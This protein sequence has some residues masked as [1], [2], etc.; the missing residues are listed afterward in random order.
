ML[1]ENIMKGGLRTATLLYTLAILALI[2]AVHAQGNGAVDGRLVNGTDPKIV[3]ANVDLDVV[4]LGGGMRILKSLTTDA[5]G[6]F[7]VDGLP[8]DSPVL[9]RANYKS[10]N[11]N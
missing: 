7:Q 8:T 9:I 10:V 4:G 5:A 11:Y 2:P 1:R 3:A 6:R